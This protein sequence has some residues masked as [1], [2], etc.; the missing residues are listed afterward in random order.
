M[1]AIKHKNYDQTFSQESKNSVEYVYNKK[2]Q[3]KIRKLRK[4]MAINRI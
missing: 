1:L 3:N 2:A 4:E